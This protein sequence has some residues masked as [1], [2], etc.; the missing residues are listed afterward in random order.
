[1][2]YTGV[3]APSHETDLY[4]PVKRFLE[5]QGFTVRA[6]VGPCDVAAVRDGRLVVVELKR[7]FGLPLVYQGI[8]RLGVADDVY[9]GVPEPGDPAGRRAWP[10][11]IREAA[12][13][14]RMLGLGLLSVRGEGVTVH[15][16][17]GPY[18]PRRRT[19][20]RGR[21]IKETLGRS[22]DHNVG[23]ATRVP[24]VTAYREDALRCADLLARTGPQSV[25]AIRN[26]TGVERCGA[27][28]LRNV[29]GWFERSGRGIYALTPAGSEALARFAPVVV[30]LRPPAGEASPRT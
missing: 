4:L 25:A 9:L 17:P 14:C 8:D 18:V 6:E 27:I 12:K 16:D 3:M 10:G 13:L 26:A 23:G 15:A 5:E 11:R 21:L 1:M 30:G 24:L 22:G 29:Y 19:K 7:A 20:E 28:L 2:E